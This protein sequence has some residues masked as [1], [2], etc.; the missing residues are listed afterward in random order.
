[1]DAATQAAT[2]S[3][4]AASVEGLRVSL[5][6]LDSKKVPK[7]KDVRLSE[8]DRSTSAP[9]SPAPSLPSTTSS[10]SQDEVFC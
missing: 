10:K 2:E 5:E 3:Q 8:G 6:A 4:V 7:K 1:M 9:T